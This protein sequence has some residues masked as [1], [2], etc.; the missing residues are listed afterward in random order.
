MSETSGTFADLR[1][2]V[3]SAIVLVAL[4]VSAIIVGG[5]AFEAFVAVLAGLMTWECARMTARD[6]PFV[7]I[8]LGGIAAL[9]VWFSKGIGAPL[10]YFALL[11]P[12]SIGLIF[13][14][15]AFLFAIFAAEITFGSYALILLHDLGGAFWLF[16]VVAVIAASDIGGYFAGR[17]LG[18]PKFWPAISPKKTWSGT[19]AGWLGAA[20]IGLGVGLW[21]TGGVNPELIGLAL[22][23]ALAGQAGDIAES[24]LKRRCGVK[25]SSALIPGHGGVFDR[26]DALTGTG[27]LIFI[28]I[29]SGY[30]FW[31]SV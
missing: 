6:N 31:Q 22:L 26:F 5:H 25:D 21:K 16:F 9:S 11:L 24:F 1:L 15:R 27:V 2:R 23:M 13:V 3:L 4:G 30:A 7:A 28:L 20:L 10:A 14:L 17:A 18:G 12:A 29:T 19:I 8:L